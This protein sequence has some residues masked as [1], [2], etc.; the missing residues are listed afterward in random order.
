VLSAPYSF[1]PDYSPKV[2]QRPGFHLPSSL[3]IRGWMGV[4]RYESVILAVSFWI[5]KG[6]A[7]R[8]RKNWAAR[9][10]R[11]PCTRDMKRAYKKAA[12]R[13]HTIDLFDLTEDCYSGKPQE[14]FSLGQ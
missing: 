5:S 13:G 9:T 11:S 10:D 4:Y 2:G 6:R 14:S 8:E 12:Q 7:R 3:P 1:F